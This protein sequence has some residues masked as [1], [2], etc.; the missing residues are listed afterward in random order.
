MLQI[1][2]ELFVFL[3]ILLRRPTMSGLFY[4][5]ITVSFVPARLKM[6]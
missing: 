3:A 4:R 5:N 1:T 2:L 6:E